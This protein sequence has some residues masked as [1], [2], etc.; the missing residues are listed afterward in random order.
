MVVALLFYSA[1]FNIRRDQ[2][3]QLIQRI[4]QCRLTAIK[5]DQPH[6]RKIHAFLDDRIGK[7]IGQMALL[8][9]EGIFR[10]KTGQMKASGMRVVTPVAIITIEGT[11]FMVRV[12][13]SGEVTVTVTSG[14]V[15]LTPLASASPVTIFAPD[16]AQ[17]FQ[18][19][20]IEFVTT[21]TTNDDGALHMPTVESFLVGWVRL[22]FDVYERMAVEP[23]A[24]LAISL[25]GVRDRHLFYP[26]I[27]MTIYA[28]ED[29][30]I[31]RDQLILDAV[32]L[33]SFRDP[34]EAIRNSVDRIWQAGGFERS[35]TLDGAF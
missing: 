32:V 18:N 30:S 10:L 5:Q 2:I 4:E 21:W 7:F 25:L 6:G 13:A 14:A 9:K 15:T 17:V 31:D 19:G 35:P 8:L 28:P 11:E 26:N 23:P 27:G 33:D 1:F 24:S 16:T 3:D 34:K 12:R 20:T 22:S 29:H